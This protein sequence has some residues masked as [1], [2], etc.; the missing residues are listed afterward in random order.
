[1]PSETKIAEIEPQGLTE[2]SVRNEPKAPQRF[3]PLCRGRVPEGARVCCHCARPLGRWR[4]WRDTI[5]TSLV[6]PLAIGALIF[7]LGQRFEQ[8]QTA[9]R[10][11]KD[12]NRLIRALKMELPQNSA[13]INNVR[14]ILTKN[15]DDLK[16]GKVSITPLISFRF[17]AWEQAQY[18]QAD[19]LDQAE[20]ADVMALKYCY[21]ILHIL[22]GKIR[23]R[24]QYR[25][26][27]EGGAG[28]VGRM[29]ALDRDILDKLDHAQR[30][31]EQAQEFLERIHQWKVKGRSFSVD[32]GLVIEEPVG[33]N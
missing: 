1:M 28:F 9:A 21:S 25:L 14:D 11:A 3:C 22:E 12:N 10:Q 5:L 29:Q 17:T 13:N 7:Y 4:R 30:V 15:L 8:A 20:T 31:L 27:H 16:N 33:R 26:L 6:V 18:G 23:N 24:E 32:R 2:D 19:F